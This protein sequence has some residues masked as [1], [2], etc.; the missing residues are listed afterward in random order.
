LDSRNYHS[1]V[2][3]TN[4]VHSGYGDLHSLSL[5]MSFSTCSQSTPCVTTASSHE[6]QIL[7]ATP[8]NNVTDCVVMD[9]KKRGSEKVDQQKQIV[10]RNSLDTFG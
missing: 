4:H 7:P 1:G 3:N 6:Q 8:A 2:H 9:T 10:H 5:S